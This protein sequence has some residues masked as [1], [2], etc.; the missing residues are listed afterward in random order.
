MLRPRYFTDQHVGTI[1]AALALLAGDVHVLEEVHLELLEAVALALLA[2]AARHV[3]GEGARREPERLGA[4]QPRE[5]LADLVE[6]LHVRD[7]IRARRAPDRLLVD[8]P[9]ALE[10]L[11]TRSSSWAPGGANSVL[12]ARATAR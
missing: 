12:N 6:G 9:D 11:E 4:R 8:E 5:E 3:E 2:A 1:A 7:G 10:V